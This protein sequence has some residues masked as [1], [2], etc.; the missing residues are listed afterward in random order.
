[1]G[2]LLSDGNRP[3]LASANTNRLFEI[4]HEDLSVADRSA[5][6]RRTNRFDRR[7][8]ERIVDRNFELNLV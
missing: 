3:G 2:R 5:M 4:E 1:M 8:D 7:L 6:S